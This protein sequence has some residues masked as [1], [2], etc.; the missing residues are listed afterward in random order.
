MASSLLEMAGTIVLQI[1]PHK[2]SL[3]GKQE[4]KFYRPPLFH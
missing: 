4:L 1:M 2:L 3:E